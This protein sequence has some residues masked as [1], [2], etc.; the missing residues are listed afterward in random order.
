MAVSRRNIIAFAPMA[1]MAVVIAGCN[2]THSTT[3]P[4]IPSQQVN[5]AD[6]D[7]ITNAYNVIHF[8]MEL[9]TMA[10]TRARDPRVKA[11]ADKILANATAFRAKVK[12]IADAK[13][14]IPPDVLRNDLRIRLGHARR[15]EGV[16]FDRVFLADEIATHQEAIER[17]EDEDQVAGADP[18]L[19]QFAA[20]GLDLLKTN[21]GQL[22]A[23]QKKIGMSME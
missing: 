19:K 1:A 12:P 15:T 9:C 11:M 13:G 17:A 22:I 21:L 8:D 2:R 23:L 3:P 6:L 16:D 18:Q 20:E 10:Q 4:G 7:F 14:I 5:Q